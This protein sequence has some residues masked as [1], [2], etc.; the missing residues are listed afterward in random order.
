MSL[1]KEIE[2]KKGISAIIPTYKGQDYIETLLNSIKNQT[3]DYKLFEAIFIVNGELDNTPQIIENFCLENPQINIVLTNSEAG[4]CNARNKGINLAQHEYTIFIDDDDYISPKYFETLLEYAQPGRVVI[5][6]FM[7]IDENTGVVK[8]SYLSKPLLEKN[9]IVEDAYQTMRDILVITTDKLIPTENVKKSK[10]NKELKNGVDIAYYSIFYAEND[11]EFYVVDKSREAIYYRLW[12]DNSISRK[13]LS[14]DFNVTD[15]LK[16]IADINKGHKIAKTRKKKSFI[17]TLSSGQVHKINQYLE[18]YPENLE[19]V[20]KDINSYNYEFFPYK[21]LNEDFEVLDNPNNELII[22]YAFPPINTTTSNMV[23]KR[24]L[25]EKNNVSV[26][27]ASL[28]NLNDDYSLEKFVNQFILDKMTIDI[29]YDTS[30]ENIK[31]F[32]QQGIEKLKE[33]SEFDKIYS[34]AFFVH[35]NYLGFAYKILH[36]NTYWKA[37]FSDPLIYNLK[38]NE[39]SPAIE[40]K[41]VVDKL[42]NYIPKDLEKIKTTDSI[43][44]IAEYL[45]YIFADEIV[46]TNKNQKKVMIDK[47]RYD[48]RDLINDKFTISKHP[49]LDKKYYYLKESNYEIDNSYVNFA[50]FGV[51]SGDRNFEDFINGLDLLDNMFKDKYRLHIFTN[52]KTLFEQVLSSDIYEKTI[53]NPTVD[54]LE[55]LNLTE[56][57]DVLLVED[58]KTQ[59]FMAKNPYLPSKISDYKGSGT[60]IWA[61]CEKDSIMDEMNIKYKSKLGDLMSSRDTANKIMEDKL[62]QSVTPKEIDIN[63]Y[64]RNRNNYLTTKIE[65]LIDV[66]QNEFRKDNV[67]ENRISQLKKENEKLSKSIENNNENN[68]KGNLKKIK[69]KI[70]K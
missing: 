65:E 56:K 58:S 8:P 43:N 19:K 63:E 55:F 41:E 66:A 54:Y 2:L 47:F 64:L 12:R 30:F 44:F 7:D 15:R 35:S 36:P 69:D 45:T 60:D 61:V 42:N 10:F 26:I 67:Y 53:I 34:R 16:V 28:K 31:E 4:V 25:T 40:D 46:F 24:I 62:N 39:I 6:T 70:L 37:E 20:I 1:R 27:C 11:F 32:T 48:V 68:F 21:Y 9:G 51:I 33:R 5:G 13:P 3:L 52:S 50:Y 17:E 57:F 18:K 22:S 23:A 49:T 14:Y 38:G 29:P 59:K